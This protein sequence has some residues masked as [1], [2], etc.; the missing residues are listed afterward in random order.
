MAL[1]PDI[2]PIV[3]ALRNVPAAEDGNDESNVVRRRTAMN[4]MTENTFLSV[5]AAGP[6]MTK[7]VTHIIA[8]P[9]GEIRVR[10]YYPCS[11]GP[12]PAFVSIHGGGWWLGN[13]DLYNHSCRA[14]AAATD[15]AVFAVGYRLAP[16]HRFP[17]AAEDCYA[18][19]CWVA[20][21]ADPIGIDPARIAVG[22]GS[23]GGNLAAVVALMARDREG[24]ALRAQILDIPVTD[25]TMS[26][27]SITSN[28][29]GYMLTRIGMEECRAFYAPDPA[30]WTNPYASPLLA[31]D[32]AN[33]PPAC[34]TTCEYD[35]LRD[36]G[37]RYGAALVAAG[38]PVLMQRALG[39]I[40]GSHHMVKLATDAAVYDRRAHAFLHQHLHE[41]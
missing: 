41:D 4:A 15:A 38:V 2:R 5:S 14:T 11:D 25:L 34:I 32:H 35:P 20:A 3:D 8:V 22:G 26:T 24:P 10:A 39:H 23:A 12:L 29:T 1:H 28:G 13:I 9:R 18:A 21:N 16:E 17:T 33:L 40:H 36:E 19:L 7:E 6:R 27:P 30:D 31:T 37:E